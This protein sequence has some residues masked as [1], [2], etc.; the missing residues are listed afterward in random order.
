[1]LGTVIYD[2]DY[3]TVILKNCIAVTQ[4]YL[5]MGNWI[6]YNLFIK[7]QC[8]KLR[9]LQKM[10]N[11]PNIDDYLKAAK[12]VSTCPRERLPYVLEIISKSGI[13]ISEVEN[14][15]EESK[16]DGMKRAYLK[17]S[18]FVSKKEW[19]FSPNPTVRRLQKAYNDGISFTVLGKISEVQRTT[20]YRYIYGERN[21]KAEHESKINEALDRIYSEGDF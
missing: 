20:L 15:I 9:R 12:I 16:A 21:M 8:C 4:K 1:M 13:E 19:L 5:T 6:Q 10:S 2:A 18:G 14:L 17:K 11:R 3:G 7:L